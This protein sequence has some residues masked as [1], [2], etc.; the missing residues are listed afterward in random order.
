MYLSETGLYVLYV[1]FISISDL[2]MVINATPLLDSCVPTLET[3]FRVLFQTS[4]SKL[5]F[6]DHL[7]QVVDLVVLQ[8]P[9]IGLYVTIKVN[10]DVLLNV[11]EVLV[12]HFQLGAL[13]QLQVLVLQLLYVL[14]V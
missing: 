4:L 3:L 12:D 7:E 2:S 8:L 11:V 1:L 14:H 5:L 9:P 13:V 10:G 6:H